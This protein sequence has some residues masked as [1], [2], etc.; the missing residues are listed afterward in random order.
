ME[1][2][3]NLSAEE[4]AL[5]KEEMLKFYE[6]SMPYLDSQLKYEKMLCD[7]DEMRFKRSQ[8]QMQYAMMMAPPEEDDKF[9]IYIIFFLSL[10][11]QI[12]LLKINLLKKINLIKK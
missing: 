5:K 1:N 11:T 12:S 3:E 7:I 8:I 6:E 9:S 4:L 10:H 2:P